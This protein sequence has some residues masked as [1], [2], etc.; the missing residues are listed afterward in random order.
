MLRFI[1]LH[2][3]SRLL[4][5]NFNT[6]HVTV[7]R[8]RKLFW[9]ADS[10]ISIH[11]MLRFI[12]TSA[13]ASALTNFISIHPMLRFIHPQTLEFVCSSIISIHPMLRFIPNL[14]GTLAKQLRFQYIP[15]YGLSMLLNEAGYSVN[16]FQYI[17][18]YG[19]SWMTWYTIWP[20]I[21]FN[22]SHVT[23]YRRRLSR[24]N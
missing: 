22:T 18:C 15:C 12:G 11:P 2:L 10:G 13:G 19:L 1:S 17:P 8:D 14:D 3:A 5:W 23:V 21:Y 16:Q 24:K 6:S 9:P 20:G 7:Y 4:N